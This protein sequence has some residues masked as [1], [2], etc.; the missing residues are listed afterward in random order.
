MDCNLSIEAAKHQLQSSEIHFNFNQFP[1]L[2]KSVEILKQE[3]WDLGSSNYNSFFRI[4]EGGFRKKTKSKPIV[5]TD[6]QRH[7]TLFVREV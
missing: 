7:A 3:F 1:M 6:S 4:F 2:R 5:F